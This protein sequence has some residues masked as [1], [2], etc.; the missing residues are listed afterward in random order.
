MAIDVHTIETKA[1]NFAS[2]L[3]VYTRK[4][5]FFYKGMGYATREDAVEA[6]GAAW[7]ANTQRYRDR[8]GPGYPP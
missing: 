5:F 6:G 3:R 8:R 4:V 7:N 1:L 2:D